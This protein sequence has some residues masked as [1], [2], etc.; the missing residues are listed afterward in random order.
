MPIQIRSATEQD[1]AAIVDLWQACGLVVAENDPV[2]DFRFVRAKPTSDILAAFDEN[3]ALI[4]S[5]AVGYDSNRGWLSY[6][7]VDPVWQGRGVGRELVSAAEQWLA[8][9][10]VT[11]V[12]LTIRATNAAMVRFY[13]R[14]GYGAMS[15]I[16]ME[17]SLPKPD[18]S[19]A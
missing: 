18:R 2:R 7:S 19:R 5:V 12:H 3:G 8:G 1:E 6:V 9:R 11:K 4:G 10:G 17:K 13:E 15:S 14:I 16:L